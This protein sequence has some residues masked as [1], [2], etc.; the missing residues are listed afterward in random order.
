LPLTDCY[1]ALEGW[2]ERDFGKPVDA[3][4]AFAELADARREWIRSTYGVTL[5]EWAPDDCVHPV[6][7]AACGEEESP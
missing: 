2:I 4:R 6:P 1:D 7:A 3:I 5:A